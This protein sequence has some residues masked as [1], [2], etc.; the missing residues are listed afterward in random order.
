MEIENAILAIGFVEVEVHVAG[1]RSGGGEA[2]V[3]IDLLRQRR[4][5]VEEHRRSRS[6]QGGEGIS[7]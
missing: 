6:Q 7:A 2:C 3:W 1:Q 4:R 5:A